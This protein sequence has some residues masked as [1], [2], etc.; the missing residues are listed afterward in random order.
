MFLELAS[1]TPPPAPPPL[2]L[3]IY[4]ATKWIH[5]SLQFHFLNP[6][7][8][9]SS[10]RDN[11]RPNEGETCT[12]KRCWKRQNRWNCKGAKIERL[13][14]PRP[15]L[16]VLPPEKKTEKKKLHPR[17]RCRSTCYFAMS[18]RVATGFRFVSLTEERQLPPYLKRMRDSCGIFPGE[19]VVVLFPDALYLSIIIRSQ[20]LQFST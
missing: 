17:Q 13:S 7:Y 10:S 15:P 11:A 9:P 8:Q 20:L 19:I 14:S 1:V 4:A 3:R 6:D 18:V 2:L 12:V 5:F 16:S